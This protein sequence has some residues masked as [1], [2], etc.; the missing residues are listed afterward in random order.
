MPERALVHFLFRLR[1]F[2]GDYLHGLCLFAPCRCDVM[3]PTRASECRVIRAAE[4]HICRESIAARAQ[5]RISLVNLSHY[6][7]RRQ[8]SMRR[9]VRVF[10]EMP[11]EMS[12][13]TR[14][15]VPYSGHK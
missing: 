14:E 12:V 15:P 6:T 1:D 11:L 10:C 9:I 8:V 13:T 2:F 3:A 4:L 5:L 7:P